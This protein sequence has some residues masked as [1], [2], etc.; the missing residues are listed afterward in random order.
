MRRL[1]TIV[2]VNLS[3]GLGD[4]TL[5][6]RDYAQKLEGQATT[7]AAESSTG[8]ALY[9]TKCGIC[10][11][12]G[13]MYPGYEALRHS[14]QRESVLSKRTD[15]KADFIKLVAREGIGQMPPLTPTYVDDR[16]LDAIAFYLEQRR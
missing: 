8:Q 3:M 10:H 2:A 9:S 1:F 6:E 7:V 13:G 12:A 15:L 4:L 11:D 16:E 14:G 5:A